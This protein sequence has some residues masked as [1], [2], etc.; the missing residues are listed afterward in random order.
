MIENN[1]GS[2]IRHNGAINEELNQSCTESKIVHMGLGI[3]K[4]VLNENHNES[5]RNSYRN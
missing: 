2:F 4:Y 1:E 5:P 3:K